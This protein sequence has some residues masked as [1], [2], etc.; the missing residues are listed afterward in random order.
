MY[1]GE[2][3][4]RGVAFCP[5]NQPAPPTHAMLKAKPLKSTK[6]SIRD[7]PSN[8][9]KN[10]KKS[11]NIALITASVIAA[12]LVSCISLASVAKYLLKKNR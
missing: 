6:T 8:A 2:Q 4:N 5:T 10:K 12:L 9:Q 1:I 7:P 3:D 11:P